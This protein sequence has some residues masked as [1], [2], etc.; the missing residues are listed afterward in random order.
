MQHA[1]PPATDQTQPADPCLDEHRHEHVFLS[2]HHG[3]N[4]RKIR[5]VIG[6]CTVMMVAEIAGGVMFR[7]MALVADGVHMSTHAAA[8][9]IA[10]AAY[11]FARKH[12]HDPRFTFGAGKF[13]DLSAFTSAVI[14]SLIAVF[15]AV[16]SGLRLLRPEPIAFDQAIPIAVLA[17]AVNALTAWFLR[18]EPHGHA[19]AE[20]A[21]DHHHHHDLNLRAAYVHVLADSA[22]SVLA[23]VGLLAGRSFGWL[24]MDPVM[25]LIGAGVIAWWAVGLIRAAGGFLLDRRADALSRQVAERLGSE[26]DTIADLHVWRLGP[27]HH[28][29]IVSLVCDQPQPP[30]AYK[31][32]L[33]DLGLSHLTIEVSPRP[34]SAVA[35]A[36][37]AAAS[38][39]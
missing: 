12:T 16:E 3:K 17:L 24:W 35:R 1:P 23:I 30:A 39:V 33:A 27:G 15:V 29:A 13:G 36:V 32:R 10:A 22:L 18:D 26:A 31:A 8:L 9:L 34:D 20:G 38:A 5:I 14:L 6:I 37:R 19:H 28:A 7:S 2:P 21:S 11:A 4:E 25:G